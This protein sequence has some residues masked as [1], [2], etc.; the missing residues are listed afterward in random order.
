M[1]LLAFSIRKNKRTLR[2]TNVRKKMRVRAAEIPA[3]A[4]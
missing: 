1:Q 3:K 2:N 4:G